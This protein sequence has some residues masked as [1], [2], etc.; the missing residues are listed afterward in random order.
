VTVAAAALPLLATL[1]QNASG[2]VRKLSDSGLPEYWSQSCIPLTVYLNGFT[3]MSRDEVAKSVA[4]GAH[5][6]GPNAVGCPDGT[7]PYLEIVTNIAGDDHGPSASTNDGRNHLTFVVE[8][9]ADL[10]PS[11]TSRPSNALALTSTWHRPDGRIVGADIELNADPLFGFVWRNLDPGVDPGGGNGLQLADLQNAVTHE[12]GHLL[13]FGHT[14]LGFDD[15]PAFDDQGQPVPDCRSASDEL[16]QTVMYNGILTEGET[17]K[18][19]LSSDEVRAVCE[20]YPE[21]SDPRN[22]TLDLPNDGC[23]CAAA[24]ASSSGSRGVLVAG[25][26]L[27]LVVIGRRRGRR[28]ARERT[29]RPG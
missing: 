7:R 12:I 15:D 11:G 17:S 4:A 22:C 28:A 10:L 8:G 14:C 29:A 2:Y 21:A 26:V 5:A 6:W 13:G 24:A 23:G 16:R 19:F 18:R 27:G 25:C 1:D 3:E 9:W 20:V